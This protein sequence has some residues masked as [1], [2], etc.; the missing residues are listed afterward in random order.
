VEAERDGLQA[1]L[2][3]AQ[4]S[5]SVRV[6]PEQFRAERREWE[7]SLSDLKA[8]LQKSRRDREVELAR[9]ENELAELRR[10]LS[11]KAVHT[12]PIQ[13]IQEIQDSANVQEMLQRQDGQELEIARREIEAERRSLQELREHEERELADAREQLA[14]FKAK[15]EERSQALELREAELNA[16]IQGP[17]PSS[18]AT[19]E[20]NDVPSAT[21][22]LPQAV[23]GEPAPPSPRAL[24]SAADVLA[25]L[26]MAPQFADV[27]LQAAEPA[28]S[29]ES[30]STGGPDLPDAAQ[31]AV[32][33]DESIENYMSRLLQRV[34]GDDVGSTSRPQ[35][36]VAP[37]PSAPPEQTVVKPAAAPTVLGALMGSEAA[38]PMTETLTPEQFIPRSQAPE[39]S[40][41]LAAMRDLA[42]TSAR[43]AI[44]RY[45]RGRLLARLLTRLVL[46]LGAAA[47]C[48]FLVLYSTGN[49]LLAKSGAGVA[50]VAA[51]FWIIR[52]L[53]HAQQF[54]RATRG[55]SKRG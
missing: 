33:D 24:E 11:E 7:Q 38:V 31:H 36:P 28:N 51:V 20:N 6:S 17:G 10:V 15:L 27:D 4:E 18:L 23:A 5:A 44:G 3:A 21:M 42:N 22:L 45:T 14:R 48:V 34:R 13:E 2:A 43:S 46:S 1:Q 52:T 32:A 40:D 53:H 49:P 37:R 41:R 9:H 50:G 47:A 29:P 35:G 55:N 12:V 39:Q 8:E 19:F 54:V 30:P 26:G 16:H 25:R